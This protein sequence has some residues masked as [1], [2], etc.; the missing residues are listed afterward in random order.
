MDNLIVVVAIVAIVVA[1]VTIVG[2]AIVA[3]YLMVLYC[4]S[5]RIS[6]AGSICCESCL[7]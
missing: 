5:Y 7:P 4:M 6:I 1:I 2:V 3:V